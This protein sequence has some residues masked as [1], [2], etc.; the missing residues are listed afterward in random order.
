MTKEKDD[1]KRSNIRGEKDRAMLYESDDER[2]HLYQSI[3]GK[4]IVI[5][6]SEE[7]SLVSI[8]LERHEFCNIIK[9]S[10]G[11]I[12]SRVS[13]DKMVAIGLMDEIVTD[14]NERKEQIKNI[15]ES[16]IFE[17]IINPEI[18]KKEHEEE[19]NEMYSTYETV[20]DL[21][22]KLALYFLT[23]V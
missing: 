9:A 3:N 20:N 14:L 23:Q 5:E 22:R 17:I 1:N 6:L 18:D 11:T 15:A 7:D 12:V 13:H 8:N 21:V 19:I 2:I 10:I 4:L 16:G